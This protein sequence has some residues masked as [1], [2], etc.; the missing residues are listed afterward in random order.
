MVGVDSVVTYQCDGCGQ[1]E[2]GDVGIAPQGWFQVPCNVSVFLCAKC[3]V[4]VLSALVDRLFLQ[5]FVNVKDFYD[6]MDA[7]KN[8]SA[9]VA[10]WQSP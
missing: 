2:S 7:V 3:K 9:V 1:E 8:E 10:Q 4:S 5:Q 6:C